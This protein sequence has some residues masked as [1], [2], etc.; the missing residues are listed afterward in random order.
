MTEIQ[1]Y[2]EDAKDLMHLASHNGTTI[3]EV[4]SVLIAAH[5]LELAS[6]HEETEEE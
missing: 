6:E 4:I 5:M 2:D 3:A 1:V